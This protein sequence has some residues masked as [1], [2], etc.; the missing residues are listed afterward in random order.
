MK[1]GRSGVSSFF[2]DAFFFSGMNAT[3]MCR[4]DCLKEARPEFGSHLDMQKQSSG[5]SIRELH[6]RNPSM[7]RKAKSHLHDQLMQGIGKD[8]ILILLEH[9]YRGS[10][11]LL[12]GSLVLAVLCVALYSL[13]LIVLM[14]VM[15]FFEWNIGSTSYTILLDW[16]RAEV[17][18]R[19]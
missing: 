15:F 2:F 3:E 1:G 4:E 8:R 10:T 6:E 19:S 11:T 16:A 18:S 5:S 9:L 13:V 12:G 7:K 17:I 14:G